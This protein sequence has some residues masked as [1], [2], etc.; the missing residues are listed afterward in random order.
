MAEITI[1][2][3]TYNTD[4]LSEAA[5]SQV[6]NLRF[7][8]Q[9]IGRMKAQLAVLQTARQAYAQALKSELPTQ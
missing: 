6:A 2:D 5:K 4:Q 9:E 1:D 3:K 7:V 8:D